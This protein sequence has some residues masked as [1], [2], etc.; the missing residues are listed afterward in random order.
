[1]VLADLAVTDGRGWRATLFWRSRR[2]RNLQRIANQCQDHSAGDV[3]TVDDDDDASDNDDNSSAASDRSSDDE[4]VL[5][6][7]AF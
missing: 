7:S 5:E 6:E 1:M 2:R 4:Q 3:G